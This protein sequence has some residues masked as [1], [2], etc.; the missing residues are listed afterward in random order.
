MFDFSLSED[1]AAVIETAQ[2]FAREQ[3]APGRREAESA[4][5]LPAVTLALA[6]SI[7]F[8]ELD[9]PESVGG[10]ALGALAHCLVTEELAAGDPGGAFQILRHGMAV[11]A[12]AAFGDAACA[13]LQGSGD[14]V[15]AVDLGRR[16]ALTQGRAKGSLPWVPADAADA[17]VLLTADGIAEIRE[18][19][20]LQPVHGSA[21]RAAGGSALTL[22]APV[23]W[24]ATDEPA[25]RRA[26]AGL[27][28]TLSA[29]AVGAMRL[30]CEQ[31]RDYAVDRVAF[32]KPIA[33]HQAM[34]FLIA[35]M[36]IAVEAARGLLHEAAWRA[37][38]RLAFEAEAASAF[39]EAAEAGMFI[40]PN[41]V[42]ILGASGFMRDGPVEKQMRE[43]RALSLIA[44]GV[45][46]ARRDT[47]TA[48]G[49]PFL[50]DAANVANVTV[51]G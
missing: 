18:G 36:R 44:G 48:Q 26:L 8:A 10:A 51:E 35:D 11:S 39:I 46:A 23:A 3:L 4:R 37:D 30:S 43:L 1:L 27:R 31:S 34:A 14:A 20:Q 19:F 5:G 41:G 2:R 6:R 25:A 50:V 24:A 42:Q 17:L 33:H 22:D 29:L 45:D 15:L 47:P 7:G 13:A 40:G 12:L 16:V 28:L 21:L 49:T 9:A 38:Q 32:G